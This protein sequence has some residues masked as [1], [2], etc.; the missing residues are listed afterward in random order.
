[1][2]ICYDSP[3][4]GIDGN[5]NCQNTICSKRDN[6]KNTVEVKQNTKHCIHSANVNLQAV[7]YPVMKFQ[8]C[9]V[10]IL[11]LNFSDSEL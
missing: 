11:F 5:N 10:R 6:N 1:M 9:I 3:N 2:V 7:L 8:P 4:R